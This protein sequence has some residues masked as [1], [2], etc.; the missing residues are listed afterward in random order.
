MS[1]DETWFG[2]LSC[3]ICCDA[4]GNANAQWASLPCG[5]VFHLSPCINDW[6]RE[7]RQAPGAQGFCPTCREPCTLRDARRLF[8]DN[9]STCASSV[10]SRAVSRSSS[11][12]RSRRNSG[13]NQ[14][15][16]RQQSPPPRGGPQ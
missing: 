8:A 10:A 16:G 4:E 14:S 6:L 11:P 12:A 1:D 13:E 7:G 9:Q 2:Q 3:S 15:S 5:H